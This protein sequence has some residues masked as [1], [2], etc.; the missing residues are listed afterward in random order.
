MTTLN[1]AI[2]TPARDEEFLLPGLAADLVRQ[3]LPPQ[4]WVIVDNGST[5]KTQ[6]V[7]RELAQQHTWVELVT[8]S[9]VAQ[10]T[11]GGPVVEAFEA[12]LAAL[13]D[14]PS[15][16]VKL[17]A[18]VGLPQN[19]FARLISEFEKNPTLGIAAG[20]RLES[21]DAGWQ[22]RHVTGTMVRAQARAY[23]RE[24][25]KG[26]LPLERCVGWDHIDQ[27]KA[28]ARG[29]Q[30]L[31]ITDLC[32]E[33]RRKEGARDGNR[34]WYIQGEAAHYLGYRP[35][36]LLLR[37]LHRAASDPAAF[38]MIG[39]YVGGLVHRRR[40][41]G[42]RWVTEKVRAQQRLSQL[43]NRISELRNGRSSVPV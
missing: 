2:I 6:T 43:P 15:V 9:G 37:T 23:R 27:L 5:D 22:V 24:C 11:R 7:A 33:H 36:Y 10:P 38:R 19:Y 35:T 28:G 26:V 13:K 8:I 14:M 42:D 41:C 31:E 30:S 21:S 29:W 20:S 17:D 25:L 4:A 3:T 12:G 39:G 16:V 34:H 18:D 32:F 40:R 1:Y